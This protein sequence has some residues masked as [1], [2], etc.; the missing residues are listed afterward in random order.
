LIDRR[1]S[2]GN[3]NGNPERMEQ[4]GVNG[5]WSIVYYR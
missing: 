5:Q 4:P 3:N 1:W 2:G